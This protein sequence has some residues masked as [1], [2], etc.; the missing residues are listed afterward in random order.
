MKKEMEKKVRKQRKAKN[1]NK[2][3]VKCREDMEYEDKKKW[4]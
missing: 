3:M 4:T 2:S 1:E